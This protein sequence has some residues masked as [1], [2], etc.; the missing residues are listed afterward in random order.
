[1]AQ[2]GP[3]VMSTREQLIEAMEDFQAGRLGVV[4]PNALMPHTGTR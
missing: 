3:F 4:P 2:Y 1:V